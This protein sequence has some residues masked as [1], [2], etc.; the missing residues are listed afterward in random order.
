MIV[1]IKS[2]YR[3][4]Y[5]KRTFFDKTTDGWILEDEQEFFQTYSKLSD[6]TQKMFIGYV[7]SYDYSEDK[8]CSISYV[9]HNRVH[10][11]DGPAEIRFSPTDFG[12]I[13]YSERWFANDRKHRRD[14]PAEIRYYDDGSVEEEVYYIN[15]QKHREDGP[16]YIHY[17]PDGTILREVYYLKNKK[18][19]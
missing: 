11:E 12:T 3:K 19:S 5:G 10:R 4:I 6:P 17:N 7:S 13:I 15:D 8:I 1:N 18:I 2:R 14:G 9:K 16:A